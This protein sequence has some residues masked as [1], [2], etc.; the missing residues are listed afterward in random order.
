MIPLCLIEEYLSSQLPHFHF[1]QSSADAHSL[2]KTERERDVRMGTGFQFVALNPPFW[3]KFV[4]L[5]EV[6]LLQAHVLQRCNY[7]R[8]NERHGINETVQVI[9]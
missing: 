4:W 3:N 1:G 5:G 8:L 7:Y 6:F 2:S 9:E